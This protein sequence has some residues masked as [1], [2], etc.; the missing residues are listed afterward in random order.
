MKTNLLLA[1]QTQVLILE[2]QEGEAT[3]FHSGPEA[4]TD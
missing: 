2:N 1:K 4:A 3:K